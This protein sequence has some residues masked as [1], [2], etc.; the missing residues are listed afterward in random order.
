MRI[1]LF[2]A[3]LI[4]SLQA[5]TWQAYT[6]VDSVIGIALPME[7]EVTDTAGYASVLLNMDSMVVLL[8]KIP[9]EQP[10]PNP[11]ALSEHYDGMCQGFLAEINGE[12]INMY[13]TTIAGLKTR[14]LHF[15]YTYP[16]PPQPFG[17]KLDPRADPE[18]Q[19]DYRRCWF[20]LVNQQVY[21]LQYW[22]MG[23]EEAPH[24]AFAD[25]LLNNLRFATNLSLDDQLNEAGKSADQ[26]AQQANLNW[27]FFIA[28][29][30]FLLIS[31]VLV[32]KLRR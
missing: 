19:T 4:T 16:K 12:S 24:I 7:P 31:Y 9:I 18:T 2:L 26:K 30:V 17:A 14:F 29:F 8:S 23:P 27:I 13:D 15:S 25:T 28:A 10:V 22:Y 21:A 32:R 11:R 20:W 3:L 5:Q 1:T 6:Q